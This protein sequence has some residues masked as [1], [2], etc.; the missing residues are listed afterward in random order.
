MT[1]SMSASAEQFHHRLT[2]GDG[3]RNAAVVL[4]G[5]ERDT[6][7]VIDGGSQFWRGGQDCPGYGTA[8][9]PCS[10]QVSDPAERLTV[11]LLQLHSP[12]TRE[13]YGPTGAMCLHQEW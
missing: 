11:G 3:R 8:S 2:G 5:V 10:A 7:G 1:V 9:R 6:E 12:A 13:T 4:G